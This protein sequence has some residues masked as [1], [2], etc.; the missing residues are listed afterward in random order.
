MRLIDI[1]IPK[2]DA[3]KLSKN[4]A[5]S[6]DFTVNDICASAHGFNEIPRFIPI[7]HISIQYFKNYC[8]YNIIIL[9]LF[10]I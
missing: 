8:V 3:G 9:I 7:H 4:K 1:N 5:V 6:Y 10:R 2:H